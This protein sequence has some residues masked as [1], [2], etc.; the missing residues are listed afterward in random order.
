MKIE[1]YDKVVESWKQYILS[2]PLSEY[3]LEIEPG[4]E[5]HIVAL[6]LF[7]DSKT[8]R[9]SGETDEFYDGYRQAATDILN[10]IGVELGQDDERKVVSVYRCTSPADIQE[11]L[12]EHIWG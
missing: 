6:A 1:D 8:V 2:G 9:A 11:E 12:K 3:E 10:F 4:L 5:Q 7:L